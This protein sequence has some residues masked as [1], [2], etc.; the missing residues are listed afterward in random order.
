SVEV[1]RGVAVSASSLQSVAA[2]IA[3][4]GI[5]PNVKSGAALAGAVGV[6][7]LERE[8]TA[9]VRDATVETIDA[10]GTDGADLTVRASAHAE[11]R[12]LVIGAALSSVGAAG[13]VATD[14]FDRT[15]T[16]EIENAN[17][18]VSGDVTVDAVT[19]QTANAMAFGAAAGTWTGL[20]AG[21][22]LMLMDGTNSARIDG[23][24]VRADSV[25]VGAEQRNVL[26][27]TTAN[28]AV[29]GGLAGAG[30][31]AVG[32]I[33]SENRA[34]IEGAALTID[35]TLAIEAD[36]WN[37]LHTIAAS[38]AAG[39]TSIAGMASVSIVGS[40]TY[41]TLADSTVDAGVSAGETQPAD[42]V[43]IAATDSLAS[44]SYGG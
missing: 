13:A 8:T 39:G 41:A 9:A 19:T 35:E 11:S 5:N 29:G 20:A 16:A 26:N 34:S 3:T 43:R 18:T 28:A 4:A 6:N 25:L 15:T 14:V 42:L 30:S 37:E 40:E 27:L 23:G 36:T 31:F 24:S 44:R 33:E 12:S 17:V 38:G 1:V 21:G 10:L 7:L 32:V 2:Y 22:V